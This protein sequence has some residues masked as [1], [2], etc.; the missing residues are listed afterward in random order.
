M[1]TTKRQGAVQ[2]GDRAE[3]DRLKDENRELRRQI[4]EYQRAEADRALREPANGGPAETNHV[5]T[6]K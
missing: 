1:A 2:S 6:T 5:K 4:S 3:L